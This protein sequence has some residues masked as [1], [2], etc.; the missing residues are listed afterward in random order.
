MDKKD[1]LRTIY[2]LDKN[3]HSNILIKIG[4]LKVDIYSNEMFEVIGDE[5]KL[6]FKIDDSVLQPTKEKVCILFSQYKGSKFK[7]LLIKNNISFESEEQ[8]LDGLPFRIYSKGK[9]VKEGDE[10]I[11]K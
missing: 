9:L 1:Y 3:D 8:F 5:F 2:R 7:D 6:P 10:N 4:D 11:I